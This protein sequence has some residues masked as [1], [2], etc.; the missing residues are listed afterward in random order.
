MGGAVNEILKKLADGD[1]R[2]IGRSEEVVAEV[3]AAPILFGELFAG[4]K[5]GDPGVR[6]RAAD[7]IEKVTARRPDLLQPY[8]IVILN[9]MTAISQ[10]EVRWHV[11]QI[12]PRLVLS[13][14]ERRRAAAMLESYLSDKSRIVRTFALQAL[15]DLTIEDN[16]LTAHVI[17]LLEA[18]TGCGVPSIESRCKRLLVKLKKL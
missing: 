14:E 15:A 9:E 7:A 6:M 13:S 18:Q 11:C 5:S 17:E 12:L 3:L 2:S 16:E 8:R 4:L 10:Q 1:L